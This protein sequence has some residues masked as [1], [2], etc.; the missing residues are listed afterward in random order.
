VKEEGRPDGVRG[1]RGWLS[2][3]WMEKVEEGE[4]EEEK[5]EEE[6]D[7]VGEEDKGRSGGGGGGSQNDEAVR[8]SAE[9]AKE[10]CDPEMARPP[11]HEAGHRWPAAPRRAG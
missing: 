6:E 3:T 4:Q 7:E 9:R 5:E 10:G 11:G 1:G 2:K 8:V